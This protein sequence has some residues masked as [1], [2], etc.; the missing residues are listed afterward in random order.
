[1]GIVI[2][3]NRPG[4]NVTG[5]SLL[6]SA[7]DSKRLELLSEIVPETAAIAALVNPKFPDVEFQLHAL[8]DAAGV[9]KRQLIF[10]RASTESELASAFADAVKQGAGA[11]LVTQDAL[12]NDRREQ[13]VA[14]AAQYK[15]PVIYP[16]REFAQK[17]G[18]A[19]NDTDF[20]DQFRQAGV[21]LGRILKGANPTDLPVVQPTKFE[22]A[23]NL[24]TARTLGLAI[25]ES[26]L[27]RADVVI[28]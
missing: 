21:Y 4:G 13:L 27:Q 26:F 5:V 6:G 9:I 8:E 28:E 1:V 25:P 16:Q 17:G 22:I 14:L 3:L 18:L 15:L 11:L 20:S 2:S 19:S 10:L 7:L 23:I 12:F 24:K